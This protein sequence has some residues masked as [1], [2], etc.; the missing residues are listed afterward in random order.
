MYFFKI[1]V[2]L[3]T[4]RLYV[5]CFQC[6]MC[7]Y[8]FIFCFL[9]S[10]LS[11]VLSISCL[12]NSLSLELPCFIGEIEREKRIVIITIVVVVVVAVAVA[13]AAAAAA[14]AVQ[15]ESERETTYDWAY[16]TT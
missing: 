11:T 14:A 2:K 5:T 16:E 9:L 4:M 10:F 6:R 1:R 8:L 7:N 15:R 3:L 13:A 12:E